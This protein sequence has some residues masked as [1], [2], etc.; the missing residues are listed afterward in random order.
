MKSNINEFEDN[1]VGLERSSGGNSGGM[2]NPPQN[3]NQH[4]PQQ[5]TGGLVKQGTSK[6]APMIQRQHSAPA[7]WWTGDPE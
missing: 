3:T 1:K 5:N 6:P 2:A 4:P 7:G